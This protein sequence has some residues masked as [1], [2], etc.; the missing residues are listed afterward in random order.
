VTPRGRRPRGND[1]ALLRRAALRLGVQAAIGTAVVVALLVA[2]AVVKLVHTQHVAADAAL[3]TA[4]ARAD[5]VD[6]PPS[7]MWLV[8]RTAKDTQSTPGLPAGLPVTG[9]LD[10]VSASGITELADDRVDGRD[11]RVLTERRDIPQLGQATVQAVLDL[12]AGQSQMVSLLRALLIGGAVGLA[13]A[14]VAGSWLARR[15]VRPLEAALGLQ[16]RFVADASHELRT[17]LTLLSTR[18]QML[19]RRLHSDADLTALRADADGV[20]V[21]AERL[22]AIL[23]D[24]LLA[25]DPRTA[26]P[27]TRVDVGKLAA[28]VVAAAAPAGQAQ[29]VTI[30]ASAT[31][32]AVVLGSPAAL[33]R[34]LTALADNAIRHAAT[35]VA[36][37]MSV[38]A[39]SVLVEVTDDGPGV[40]E[41]M[42]PRL[43]ERFASTDDGRGAGPRRYGLGLA[44]VNEVAD[45]HGGRV[46]VA[47]GATG[48]AS[49]RLELPRLP[50]RPG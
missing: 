50:G 2:V 48:G 24:L 19:R 13:L 49:F 17:P 29:G 45:R 38:T 18:A 23:D 10:R 5:D 36:V 7:G 28:E 33:R 46:S 47:N 16:R 8:I 9:A 6:D 32:Q 41:E 21:D 37:A 3:A 22:A 43:F 39:G 15:A 20:V 14:A 4:V 1:A 44:L 26:V 40:D 27:D 12:G 30:S 31:G 42:L 34:A 35:E 25:A 11:L